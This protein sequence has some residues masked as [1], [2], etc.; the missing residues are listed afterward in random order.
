MGAGA[1]S[2]TFRAVVERALVEALRKEEN[3]KKLASAL[4]LELRDGLR[5]EGYSIHRRGECV[6]P[7]GPKPSEIGRPMTE[8]EALAF[9]IS[10]VPEAHDAVPIE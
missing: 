7:R 2:A 6:H 10:L 9:G 1:M 3:P 5:A 8:E 4:A